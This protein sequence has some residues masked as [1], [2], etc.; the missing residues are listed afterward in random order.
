MKYLLDTNIFLEIILRQVRSAVSKQFILE[1]LQE[2]AI[3]DFSLHSIGVILYRRKKLHLYA[4]F[5]R[6]LGEKLQLVVLPVDALENIHSVI[7]ESGLDFD[8]AY[9]LIAAQTF[10]LE[11]VTFDRDF[12]RVVSGVSVHLL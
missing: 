5:I 8:D 6:D 3:S 12:R 9:Q 10:G 2:I 1:H 7:T 4:E 11:I